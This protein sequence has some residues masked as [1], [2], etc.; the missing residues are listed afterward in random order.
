MSGKSQKSH[1]V[2]TLVVT[3]LITLIS[4]H[5]NV[6]ISKKRCGPR[7]MSRMGG[8]KSDAVI[9]SHFRLDSYVE[10]T[11]QQ[12]NPGLIARLGAI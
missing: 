3:I 1:F 5:E 2:E 4:N 11:V 9:S 8:L 12:T 7:A 6:L 10:D